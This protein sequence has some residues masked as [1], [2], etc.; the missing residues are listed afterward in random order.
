MRIA[1]IVGMD[2]VTGKSEPL[3]SGTPQEMRS[4]MKAYK[5]G[6]KCKFNHIRMY[7]RAYQRVNLKQKVKTKEKDGKD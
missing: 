4:E 1:V 3:C 2:L 6:K 7:E 5:S